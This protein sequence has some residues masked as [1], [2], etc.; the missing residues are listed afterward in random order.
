M[1][2]SSTMTPTQPHPN[3]RTV[4]LLGLSNFYNPGVLA[5]GASSQG[6]IGILKRDIFTN[7]GSTLTPPFRAKNISK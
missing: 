4:G 7:K 3:Y 6:G 2:S 5:V 1:W